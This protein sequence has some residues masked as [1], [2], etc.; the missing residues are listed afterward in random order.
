VLKEI[1]KYPVQEVEYVEIDPALLPFVEPVV[2]IQDRQALHDSRV[3]TVFMDGRD[4]L[5][6]PMPLFDVIVMNVGEP[7][8]ASLNRFY[9]AEFFKHCYRS[10]NRDGIFAFSFPSSDEYIADELKDLDASLYQTLKHVFANTL[11]IPGTHAILIGTTSTLPFISQ[12][13]SL[14]H[15]FALSGISAE[16]FTQYT[17]AELMPP[18]QIKSITNTIES[19]KNVRLNTDNDPVTY[20]FDL[21]LWNKFLQDS[22]RFFSFL[23][24][25]WIYTAG[26]VTSGFMVLFILLK[27][28][29]PEKQKRTALA[30]IISVCGMTGMAL[31]LLFLLNFQEAFGSI[32][33]M[34]GAM[35]A[36]NML[37]L[38]LGVLGASRLLKKY[39]QQSLLLPALIA[40]ICLVLLLPN[41]LNV[42]LTAQ[43]IP[44]TLVATVLSG[45]LIGVLFGIVNRWYLKGSSSA[46]SVYAFD[47]IGSS[48]GALTT[49]SVLLPVLGIQGVTF[50][51]LLLLVP[52]VL[53]MV[54]LPE[55]L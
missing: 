20:Y 6:L 9:S 24:R 35:I 41:L 13:D 44:A 45:G 4:F 22:N 47:V 43:L 34:M 49:C 8:T 23:S 11:I 50:F 52:A 37:G 25:F 36:A 53:T 32:Y 15:R 46:G 40:L 21:L 2:N 55:V 51:L 18:D 33:E 28:K 42:L 31:N 17:F 7:S 38:A 1:L 26:A 3:H 48:L 12:P 14:A 5:R 19:A 30:V 27:R 39:Q 10:L 54:L 29:Q 16:Y